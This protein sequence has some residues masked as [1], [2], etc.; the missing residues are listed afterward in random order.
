MQTIAYQV[1]SAPFNKP[2]ADVILRTSDGVD[3]HVHKM[4]LSLASSFF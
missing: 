2:S 1:A 3:F 4:L